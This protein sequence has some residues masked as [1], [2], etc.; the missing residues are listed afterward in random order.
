MQ[1]ITL[2]ILRFYGEF[3][4]QVLIFDPIDFL[5]LLCIRESLNSP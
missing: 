4:F 3:K 2:V 1:I 5:T